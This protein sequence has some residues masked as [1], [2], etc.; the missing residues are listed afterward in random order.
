MRNPQ[1]LTLFALILLCVTMLPTEAAEPESTPAPTAAVAVAVAVLDTTGSWRMFHVLKP[2]EIAFDD[3]IRPAVF[4][5]RWLREET[6]APPADWAAPEFDDSNWLRG[7]A[8]MACKTPFVARAC[9]RGKFRVADP[10]K[11]RGLTLSLDY[12]GGV[13]VRLNGKELSRKHVVPGQLDLAAAYPLETFVGPDGVML[14]ADREM[15]MKDR[16]MVQV[17]QPTTEALRRMALRKRTLANLPIPAEALR[18]GINVLAIEVLRSPYH[19]VADEL[20][21]GDAAAPVYDLHWNTCELLSLRL[22]AAGPKGLEPNVARPQGLQVWNGSLLRADFQLDFGDPCEPLGPVTLTG[23]RGGAFS[24]KVVTGCDQPIKGLGAAAT[25]LRGPAG[26]IPASAVRVRYGWPGGAEYGAERYMYGFGSRPPYSASCGALGV[27]RDDP[28]P[29]VPLYQP[30]AKRTDGIAAVPGA[31]APVWIT[32]KVPSDTKP[33]R[34]EGTLTIEADHRPPV[35]TPVRLEVLDWSLPEPQDFKTWIELVQSPD[36][37]QLEYAVP[38]WSKEH[39]DLI[40][41][42][43]R[44]LREVGSGV[45]YVP[46]LCETN[47]G[48]AESMVRWIRKSPDQ[49]DFDFSVMDKYLDVAL[50]NLGQ[51]KVLCFIAWEVYLLPVNDNSRL[52]RTLGK[53]RNVQPK[54]SILD[55]ATGKVSTEAVPNYDDPAMKPVWKSL[56]DQLRKRLAARGLEPA[57]MVGWMCDSKPSKEEVFFWREVTGDLP[58]V[59]HSHW[60][61]SHPYYYGKVLGSGF[62]TGYMTSIYQVTFPDDPAVKRLY[63][64]KNPLLHAQN[65]RSPP[66]EMVPHSFCHSMGEIN[67]TGG[68]RGFGRLGGDYWPAIKDRQGQRVGKAYDRYPNSSWLNI[69]LSNSLL[70]PGPDGA[71]ATTRFEALREGVQEC[72]ARIFIETALTDDTLRARLGRPL[73]ARCQAF[74][75]QRT[76]N[77]QRSVANFEVNCYGYYTPWNWV[78]QEGVA[79]HVWFQ[80]SSWRQSSARLYALAAEAA[81]KLPQR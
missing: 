2:P 55:P 80:S 37:L 34:Y 30:D 12:H 8:L 47:H 58:W 45:L 10:S 60:P 11:V 63:G 79:G 81:A 7:P 31:V 78:W 39:W 68:Q 53:E 41:R 64:W 9:F 50:E 18:P 38:L 5:Q 33:G 59:S 61:T 25:E 69:N 1:A 54:V 32:V 75:D 44:F 77:I 49:Y 15:V 56:F 19:K 70:A 67:I 22:S 6:A 65:T 40:A 66:L 46:L 27:L 72:E 43:M 13:I 52:G 20:K 17:G 36:T 62:K 4:A 26:T 51:P 23:I 21:T 35:V 42:S 24:G 29:E 14:A 57:M 71:V 28:P 48:N 73:A 16:Q 3:G 74:L 76:V